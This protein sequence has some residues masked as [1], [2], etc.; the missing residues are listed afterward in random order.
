MSSSSDDD[1]AARVPPA[2]KKMHAGYH[3]WMKSIPK[4]S[5]DFTPARIDAAPQQQ[6]QQAAA[7]G[8]SAW[9]A[10]GTWCAPSRLFAL[11]ASG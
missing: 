10:A 11:H 8:N 9:N 4:T 3:G 1:D 7:T 6:Q 2:A 5:Q